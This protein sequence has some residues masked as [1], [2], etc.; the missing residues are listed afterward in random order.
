MSGRRSTRNREI[1]LGRGS[2]P[3]IR[4]AD[5][6]RLHPSCGEAVSSAR[7]G[8]S[9]LVQL[10]LDPSD[11]SAVAAMVKNGAQGGRTHFAPPASGLRSNDSLTAPVGPGWRRSTCWPHAAVASGAS[12]PPRSTVRPPSVSLRAAGWFVRRLRHPEVEACLAATSVATRRLHPSS[13]RAAQLWLAGTSAA[14]ELAG[15]DSAKPPGTGPQRPR[16]TPAHT[17]R[18]RVAHAALLRP[19]ECG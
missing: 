4:T 9:Q 8:A 15:L 3:A 12:S 19:D 17:V 13:E 6:S 2:P 16:T 11:G 14:G 10:R 7:A 5:R 18:R 1:G